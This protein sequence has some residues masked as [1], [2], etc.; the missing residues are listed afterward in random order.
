MVVSRPGF[1]VERVARSG[2]PRWRI[3]CQRAGAQVATA[4]RATRI[5][6][7]FL[8]DAPTPDVSSTEIRRGWRRASRSRTRARRG[9]AAHRA[10]RSLYGRRRTSCGRS[11]AWR[12]L[13][14]AERRQSGKKRLTGEVGKAVRAALD[15]KAPDVVVLDLRNTPAFTDFFILCSGQST[16]Q[17][18]AIADAV[19][20]ALRAVEVRPAHVEGYDRA[21]W[22]LMDYFTFIVHVF[23][24]QTRAFYSLERLWGDAERIEV[25]TSRRCGA[26][27][28]LVACRHDSSRDAPPRACS[29]APACAACQRPLD[30]PTRGPVCHGCWAAIVPITPPCCDACGDPLPSWR[31]ISLECS[32]CPRC[33]RRDLRG[34]AWPGDRRLRRL[35]ARDR[36]RAQVRRTALARAA[37]GAR[38]WRS[39]GASVLDGADVVVPVPLHRSAAAHARLQPGGG[40]RA[41]PSPSP[42]R[43]RCGASRATASQTDLPAAKRHA[44][45]R[46]AFALAAPRRCHECKWWCWWTT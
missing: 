5:A 35:A 37:A 22:V 3:G 14:N 8:V 9:R 16:R 10:A 25:T 21:E 1:P 19:E 44:N 42:P 12:K 20:E 23:T 45:V 18:K 7:I 32:R 28:R 13:K 27:G 24:P 34:G 2:C 31:T 46:D 43:T 38:C 36:P 33:R 39:T 41:A 15:K 6:E 30:E 4:S 40:N 11:L 29:L 26:R 17:V